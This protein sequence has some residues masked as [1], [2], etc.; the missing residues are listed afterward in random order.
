MKN[1]FTNPVLLNREFKLPTDGWYHLVP[2][3]EFPVRIMERGRPVVKMQI[4]DD[5]ALNSMVNRFT[6]EAKVENFPGL[7]IDYDHFSIDEDKSSEAAGWIFNTQIRPDGLWGE[8]RWADTGEEAITGGRFRMVSPLWNRCD[9]QDLGDNRVRP[10]RLHNAALTNDPNLKGMTPLSNR[11]GEPE[12]G[13][14]DNM[15]YKAKL[16]TLLGAKEDA[17]DADIDGAIVNA[18]PKLQGFDQLQTDHDAIKNRA[19]AL[20]EEQ[21]DADLET[22]KD[23]ITDKDSVRSELIRNR[24][25]TIS[26][27]KGLKK[28]EAPKPI[29]NRSRATPP[30]TDAA[31]QADAKENAKAARIKNRAGQ[32]RKDTPGTTFITAWNQAKSEVEAQG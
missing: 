8:I 17:S 22:F 26:L 5:A 29:H 16:I 9:C 10:M 7:L 12:T 18:A 13:G 20:L 2:K 25:A 4:L 3:G 23:V 24:E 32:I 14:E 30:A 31:G 28:P 11:R 19:D 6:E 27:L 15:D 21:A 1:G